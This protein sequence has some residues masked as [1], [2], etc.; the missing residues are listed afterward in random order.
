[1]LCFMSIAP[2]SEMPVPRSNICQTQSSVIAVESNSVGTVVSSLDQRQ[3]TIS[4][5]VVT[6]TVQPLCNTLIES[7]SSS[8]KPLVN[9]NNCI[10]LLNKFN[11]EQLTLKTDAVNDSNLK[12]QDNNMQPATRYRI[13]TLSPELNK[14][15]IKTAS[16][17]PQSSSSSPGET[18]TNHCPR[19]HIHTRPH[20]STTA[21]LPPHTNVGV[22][23]PS[24]HGPP[25]C[26]L[27][28]CVPHGRH[29]HTRAPCPEKYKN[30]GIDVKNPIVIDSD[31]ED[32]QKD[33]GS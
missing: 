30:K 23:L 33:Q 18:R 32:E 27:G 10:E 28:K 31:D 25:H 24:S 4:T 14:T 12:V 1:M 20:S 29:I 3:S 8:S 9:S 7:S 26:F 22:H 16:G 6:N 2:S 5:P 15:D 21:V 11:S 17:S 13:I 19:N